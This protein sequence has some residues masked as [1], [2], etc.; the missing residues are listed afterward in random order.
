MNKSCN[1]SSAGIVAVAELPLLMNT[2]SPTDECPKTK[3]D[4]LMEYTN[5]FIQTP[6][7]YL[8]NEPNFETKFVSAS[9]QFRKYAETLSQ[10]NTEI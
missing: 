7:S 2:S 5:D 1:T 10:A 8:N 9:Q 4:I 3:K 6:K